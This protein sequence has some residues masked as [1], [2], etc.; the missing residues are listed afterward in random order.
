MYTLPRPLAEVPSVARVDS[1]PLVCSGVPLGDTS[2][3]STVSS[4]NQSFRIASAGS[5]TTSNVP[6]YFSGEKMLVNNVDL[7]HESTT[8]PTVS[9]PP[10]MGSVVNSEAAL[11]S[12]IHPMVTRS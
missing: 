12:N 5:P 3:L 1:S 8:S 9:L 10:A 6:P 7:H 11:C 2:P 4:M